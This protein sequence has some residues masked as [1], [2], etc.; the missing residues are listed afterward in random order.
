MAIGVQ[1]VLLQI[2]NAP[3]WAAKK[4]LPWACFRAMK[5]ES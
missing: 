2:D 4:V 1:W 5:G 3:V